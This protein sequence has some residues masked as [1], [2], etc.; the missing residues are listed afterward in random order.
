MSNVIT[1]A[2]SGYVYEGSID[3]VVKECPTCHITYAIPEQLDEAA[4]KYNR[5]EW[6]NNTLSF[7]CP[8]GHSLSYPGRNEEQLLRR[9]LDAA[10][11]H[12]ATLTARL[13]Q[14]EASRR[15]NKAAAT[16][17][18]NERDRILQRI[19][20]GVCPCCNRS[21]KNVRRHMASQHP[22][23]EIPGAES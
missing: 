18:R 20:G 16:R 11:D 2:T 9:R 8:N 5:A 10:K 15:A 23:Y 19:K 22:D 1:A 21:F 4:Q 7:Y 3:L 14:T 13:D 12:N 17:A 6:P